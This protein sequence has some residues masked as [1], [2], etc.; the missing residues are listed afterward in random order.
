MNVVAENN[1]FLNIRPLFIHGLDCLTSRRYD[2]QVR[3][4][5]RKQNF[6]VLETSTDARVTVKRIFVRRLAA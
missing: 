5:A 4:T 6:S 1:C 2:M 3:D